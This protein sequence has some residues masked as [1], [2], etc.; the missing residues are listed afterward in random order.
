MKPQS[1]TTKN[2]PSWIHGYKINVAGV[3]VRAADGIGAY[4]CAGYTLRIGAKTNDN[5]VESK[6]AISIHKDYYEGVLNG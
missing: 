5:Y 1:C 4:N 2:M 6:K 3:F